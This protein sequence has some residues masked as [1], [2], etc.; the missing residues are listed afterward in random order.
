MTA[1]RGIGVVV[2]AHDEEEL[3]VGCLTAIGAAVRALS[4]DA[5]DETL[6]SVVIVALDACRDGSADVVARCPGVV[7]LV[8]DQRNVGRARAAG[9]TE[10][11]RR[12][13]LPDDAVWLATTDADC[14]VPPTWL[15]AQRDA[16]DAGADAVVGTVRVADWSSHPPEVA[17]RFAELYAHAGREHP[18]VHGANLG[19]RAS[20]LR[21]AGGVPP[22]ALAEDVALVAALERTGAR[23]LR[24]AEVPVVTSA[25]PLS[26]TRGGFADLLRS[27]SA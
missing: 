5:G 21:R 18:H 19:V 27:L 8:V 9:V 14:A 22:L 20:A 2:P 12:L 15:T 10:S 4:S 25:R 3:L 16:A 23:V 1:L 11:L 24:S 6:R 17:S 26:R 7:P 13:A